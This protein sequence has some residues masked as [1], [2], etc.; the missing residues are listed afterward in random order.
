MR[1]GQRDKIDILPDA[2]NVLSPKRAGLVWASPECTSFI[3]EGWLPDTDTQFID[4]AGQDHI[5]DIHIER[6]KD[7]KMMINRFSIDHYLYVTGYGLKMKPDQS[8]FP[9]SRLSERL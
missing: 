2:C 5:R 6:Q 3:E 8:S 4:P 7:T 9:I 1:N